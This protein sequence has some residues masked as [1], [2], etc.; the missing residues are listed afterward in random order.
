[1]REFPSLARACR[2]TAEAIG[3]IV[4]L[5][6]RFTPHPTL[7]PEGRGIDRE[8]TTNGAHR[9]LTKIMVLREAPLRT[10][11]TENQRIKS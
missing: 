4:A 7:S 9:R 6:A 2:A 5:H 3:E 10:L 11:N 1:M 8:P